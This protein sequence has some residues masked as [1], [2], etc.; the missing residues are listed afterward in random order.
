[1]SFDLM[2]L[3]QSSA[4]VI[5]ASMA[6]S[7]WGWT[8]GRLGQLLSRRT[9][10]TSDPLAVLDATHDTVEHNAG[11]ATLQDAQSQLH[12][13]LYHRLLTDSDLAGPLADLV[14]EIGNKINVSDR[15]QLINQSAQVSHGG[16]AIQAGRDA[17]GGGR[18]A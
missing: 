17:Y 12:A 10:D 14:K 8:R 2:A 11:A 15:R 7:A 6:T 18:P 16:T 5:A 1:M 9:D 3:A 4:Q 13:L